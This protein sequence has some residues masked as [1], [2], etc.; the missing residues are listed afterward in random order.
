MN[1]Y[2]CSK[3]WILKDFS[4][5]HKD[6]NSKTWYR[7][8]CKLCHNTSINNYNNRKKIEEINDLISL[9]IINWVQPIIE[10]PIIEIPTNRKKK[11]FVEERKLNEKPWCYPQ[12]SDYELSWQKEAIDLDRPHPSLKEHI[13]CTM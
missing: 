8:N 11:W 3:C 1:K 4:Q 10:I 2:T 6:Y 5:F 7:R 12:E 9:K 13:K